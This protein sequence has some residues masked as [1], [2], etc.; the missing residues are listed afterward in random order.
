MSE[1]PLDKFIPFHNE[2]SKIRPDGKGVISY[3]DGPGGFEPRPGG[4]FIRKS[5]P[6]ATWK[7]QSHVF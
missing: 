4:D 7:D 3:S 5:H 1:K 6:G 2:I